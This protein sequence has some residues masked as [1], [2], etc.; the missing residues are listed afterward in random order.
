VHDTPEREQERRLAQLAREAILLVTP[1][2]EA[3]GHDAHHAR[4]VAILRAPGGQTV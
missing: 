2:V 3:A 1:E 4:A